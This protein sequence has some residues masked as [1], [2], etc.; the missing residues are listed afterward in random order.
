MI[1]EDGASYEKSKRRPKVRLKGRW[2]QAAGFPI[3]KYVELSIPCPG[4]IEMRV[5]GA[6]EARKPRLPG[7]AVRAQDPDFDVLDSNRRELEAL[8]RQAD[9]K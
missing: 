7:P 6:S 4:V 8:F 2:L 3:G 1:E 5:C 9:T